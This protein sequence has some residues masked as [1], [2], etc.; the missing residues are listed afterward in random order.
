MK[1]FRETLFSDDTIESKAAKKGES[2]GTAPG[3]P[4]QL[5]S[6]TWIPVDFTFNDTP[7]RFFFA[8]VDDKHLTY[9]TAYTLTDADEPV[10]TVLSTLV[11]A[12]PEE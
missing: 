11:V 6:Y 9:I 10:K 1:I 7:S 2:Y 4:F 3:E 5:G 12:P 8:P